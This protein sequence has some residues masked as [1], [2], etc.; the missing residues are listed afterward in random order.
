MECVNT[1]DALYNTVI[2]FNNYSTKIKEKVSEETAINSFLDTILEVQKNID[3]KTSILKSINGLYNK[4][5][6]FTDLDEE[7]LNIIRDMVDRGK[8]TKTVLAKYYV[9]INKL[10]KRNIVNNSLNC[11]K[12]EFDNFKEHL[13]DIEDLFFNLPS[14]DEYNELVNELS[15]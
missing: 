1:K 15:K 9:N 10:R 3:S 5:S 2:E 7:S 6:W 11:F 12:T 4:L 8:K 14:D 13:V